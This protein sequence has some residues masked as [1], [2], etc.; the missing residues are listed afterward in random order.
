M[1]AS[2]ESEAHHG[3]KD[4]IVRTSDGGQNTIRYALP[5]LPPSSPPTNPPYRSTVFDKYR[6]SDF[7]PAGYD[8]R[9]VVNETF[10][11]HESGVDEETIHLR[12]K[13]A[14]KVADWD[15]LTAFV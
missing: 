6:G 12:Y 13:A 7:W 8:G 4:L 11:E 9:G 14:E 5:P 15:R 2:V 10:R 1:A 3:F